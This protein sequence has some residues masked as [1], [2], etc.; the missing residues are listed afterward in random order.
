MLFGITSHIYSFLWSLVVRCHLTDEVLLCTE[1]W[2]ILLNVP[3]E[4]QY[5]AIAHREWQRK[6]NAQIVWQFREILLSLQHGV[7]H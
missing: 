1:E 7:A 3:T 2:R 5:K 4:W 6:P